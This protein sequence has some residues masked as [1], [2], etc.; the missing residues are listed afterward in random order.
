MS[1]NAEQ[2][3]VKTEQL[4]EKIKKL[5][6]YNGSK[7]D[8]QVQIQRKNQ[9]LNIL[10]LIPNTRVVFNHNGAIQ[11]GLDFRPQTENLLF[12]VQEPKINNICEFLKANQALIQ[13]MNEELNRKENLGYIQAKLTDF[14]KRMT[15][16]KAEVKAPKNRSLF[17]DATYERFHSFAR[18]AKNFSDTAEVLL[19]KASVKYYR[20]IQ[21]TPFSKEEIGDLIKAG[22]YL[23]QGAE[24]HHEIQQRIEAR[25][26]RLREIK[27]LYADLL[28]CQSPAVGER[29]PAIGDRQRVLIQTPRAAESELNESGSEPDDSRSEHDESR[30]AIRI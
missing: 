26:T 22:L 23:R 7:K 11:R 12:A 30:S 18:E 10:E 15:A 9:L 3:F 13:K 17:D 19:R 20:S 6:P 21:R 27:A 16:L 8:I 28:G 1:T 14:R 25:E 4:K 5:Y 24:V 2:V 29:Q